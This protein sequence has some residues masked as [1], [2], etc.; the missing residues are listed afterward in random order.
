M[1]IRRKAALRRQNELTA[2]EA[3]E[4]VLGPHANG[5]AFPSEEERRAAWEAHRDEILAEQYGCWAAREYDDPD[6]D[7]DAAPWAGSAG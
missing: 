2:G 6:P 1:A 3:L 5:S 7:E 4:L